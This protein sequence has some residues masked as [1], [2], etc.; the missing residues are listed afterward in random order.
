MRE[1]VCARC[2]DFCLSVAIRTLTL[3][4]AVSGPAPAR[5]GIGAGIVIDSDAEAEFEECLLKARFVTGADSGLAGPTSRP[6]QL[7]C[8]A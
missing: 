7:A 3:G 6:A 4:E 8:A 2:G 5:L 1:H